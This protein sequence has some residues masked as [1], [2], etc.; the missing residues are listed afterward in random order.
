MDVYKL[1]TICN[2]FDIVM[3]DFNNNL[4]GKMKAIAIEIIHCLPDNKGR[5]LAISTLLY[6]AAFI[7]SSII[8][9]SVTHNKQIHLFMSDDEARANR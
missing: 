9:D 2:D 8:E 4:S 1:E 5:N 7:K 6:A 3:Q